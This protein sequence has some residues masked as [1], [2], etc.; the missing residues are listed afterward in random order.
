MSPRVLV[1]RRVYF[2]GAANITN[3][4]PSGSASGSFRAPDGQVRL[5]A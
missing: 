3:T 2:S 1:T 4:C 5:I